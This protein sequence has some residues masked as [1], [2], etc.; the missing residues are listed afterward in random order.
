VSEH[1]IPGETGE[2]GAT[3]EWEAVIGLEDHAKLFSDAAT[4]LVAC[5]KKCY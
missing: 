4:A 2:T 1:R 3:G 5:D